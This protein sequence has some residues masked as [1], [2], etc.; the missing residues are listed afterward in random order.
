MALPVLATVAELADWIGEP[1]TEPS[2]AKRAQGVLRLASALVRN[3][4]GGKTWAEGEQL[5]PD[6]PD[7]LGL[8]TLACA[9]RGYT[10]PEAATTEG[11]DDG[12]L[13]RVVE[14]A[15]LYLTESE[16]RLLEPYSA[17][18]FRGLSTVAT[19]RGESAPRSLR[20]VTDPD[21]GE[22]ILPPYY[23]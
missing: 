22:A 10:N 2:D 8:V 20:A 15:G 7:D 9:A 3:A 13:G 5:L 14:E 1:I 21:Y 11:I 6:I 23:L 19:T 16:K 17:K 12:Q 18:P 4:T